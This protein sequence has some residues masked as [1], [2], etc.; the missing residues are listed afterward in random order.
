MRSRRTAA[1]PPGFRLV[2]LLH[3]GAGEGQLIFGIAI[4]KERERGIAVP[5]VP[6]AS[7]KGATADYRIRKFKDHATVSSL[8]AGKIENA[9]LKGRFA[10]PLLCSRRECVIRL[11]RAAARERSDQVAAEQAGRTTESL[12]AT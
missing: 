6:M 4:H 3:F 9:C 1:I 5:V 7:G 12:D 2:E 8:R 10:P 11:L